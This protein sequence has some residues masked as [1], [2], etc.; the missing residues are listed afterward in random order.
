MKIT[1]TDNHQQ[2]FQFVDKI[3]KVVAVE[4]G[5]P[6]DLLPWIECSEL[7]DW[8]NYNYDRD[9]ISRIKNEA[10]SLLRSNH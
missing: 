5:C 9:V 10:R 3:F 1:E 7:M 6:E 2:I 8:F 4:L